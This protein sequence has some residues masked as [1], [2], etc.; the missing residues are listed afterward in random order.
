MTG[1]CCDWHPHRVIL[2]VE[3]WIGPL[4]A[5]TVSLVAVA[6]SRRSPDAWAP[7][8]GWSISPG[9]GELQKKPLPRSGGYAMVASF[10]VAVGLVWRSFPETYR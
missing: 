6:I 10:L 4:V 9:S 2:S 1:R 7:N 3:R 8:S 5:F